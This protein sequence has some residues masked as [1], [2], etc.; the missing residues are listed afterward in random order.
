MINLDTYVKHIYQVFDESTICL[1]RIL[2]WYNERVYNCTVLLYVATS[3]LTIYYIYY[4][5]SLQ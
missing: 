2:F 4:T 5:K 1:K 3:M